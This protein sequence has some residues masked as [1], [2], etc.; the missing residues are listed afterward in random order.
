[1]ESVPTLRDPTHV[2]VTKGTSLFTAPVRTSTSVWTTHVTTLRDALILREVTSA[3]AWTRSSRTGKPR[4]AYAP[5]GMKTKTVNVLTLTSVRI[6]LVA[7]LRS[8]LTML[9]NTIATAR[10][11]LRKVKMVHVKNLNTL[12][13]T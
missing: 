13:V 10:R 4:N 11:E 2:T 1:M 3:T 12:S 8:V 5:T 7:K 6:I 9:E